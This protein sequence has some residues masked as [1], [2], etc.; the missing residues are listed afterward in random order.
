MTPLPD[1]GEVIEFTKVPPG[2]LIPVP[3][4]GQPRHRFRVEHK[5]LDREYLLVDVVS[6]HAARVPSHEFKR[7]E[8]AVVSRET[9]DQ[10]AKAKADRK[11]EPSI[12]KPLS[13]ESQGGVLDLKPLQDP[14]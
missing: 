5:P 12:A 3:V 6:G 9:L 11:A 2:S 13:S 10:E 14:Q 1:D 4:E 7:G 8:W